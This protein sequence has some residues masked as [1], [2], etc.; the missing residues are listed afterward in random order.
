MPKVGIDALIYRYADNSNKL[1]AVSDATNNPA[2]F[3]DGNTSGDDYAYDAAGSL[4]KDLNKGISSIAYNHLK[5]PRQVSFSNGKVIDYQYDASGTKLKTTVSGG[6]GGGGTSVTEY[7]GN[8]VWLNGALLQVAHEEGRYT[9]GG[10]YEWSLSDHLGNL[11]VS[12][13][14]SNG[15]AQLV[16]SQHYDPWGWE[17]P[18]LGA[19]G[20]NKYT[21]NGKEKQLE[22]GLLDFNW[23]YADPLLGRFFVI[24]R[25]A[26]KFAYMTPYQFASNDP[27]GKIELDGLEGVRHDEVY[28]DGKGK[29]RTKT[30]AD[31]TVYVGIS[32]SG[33]TTEDASTIIS[34]LNQ[35]YNNDFKVDGKKIEFN[36]NLQTYDASA[37][38]VAD[39]AKEVRKSSTVDALSPTAKDDAGNANP[40]KAITGYVIALDPALSSQKGLQG[41][42]NI[43][44]TRI[45]PLAEDKRHTEAHEIGHFML[46]GNTN[47]PFTA[48]E[49]NS[50]G[51][52]FIYKSVDES[53]NTTQSTQ[54]VNRANVKQIIQTMPIRRNYLPYSLIST[55]TIPSSGLRLYNVSRKNVL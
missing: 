49:H 43:N 31:V 30:I 1:L 29:E 53:G 47:N 23:R 35:Q 28:K 8:Q 5:L 42:T 48:S 40:I 25:L 34:N 12:F 24:D 27:V 51:G 32:K 50:A 38:S 17:L 39:K 36:F 21:F 4:S 20:S 11:R 7:V 52:I 37:I 46:Q 15:A 6:G 44:G 18:G 19:A 16:Q 26:E 10:G 54:N 33:Y 13:V 2:G 14:N 3:S 22:T 55:C 9:P 45:S 41:S